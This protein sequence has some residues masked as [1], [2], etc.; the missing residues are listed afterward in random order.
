MQLAHAIERSVAEVFMVSSKLS[1]FYGL[2][3]WFLHNLFQ[4]HI[5]YVPT[6]IAALLAAVP[7]LPTYVVCL[8]GILDL[9]LLQENT[10]AAVLLLLLQFAPQI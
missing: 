4:M 9:W 8:P 7:V 5:V 6:V 10:L 1:L 3:T 2:Y